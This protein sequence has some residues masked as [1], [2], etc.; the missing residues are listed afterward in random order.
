MAA[1]R[2]E[3]RARFHQV[4]ARAI[5]RAD[6]EIAAHHAKIAALPKL[7]PKGRERIADLL[8]PTRRAPHEGDR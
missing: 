8:R 6:R 2:A 1:P 3:V 4:V 7:P 5:A